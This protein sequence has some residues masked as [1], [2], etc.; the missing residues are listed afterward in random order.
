LEPRLFARFPLTSLLLLAVAVAVK[1]LALV[2][3]AAAAV[4]VDIERQQGLQAVAHRQNQ[5]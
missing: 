5:P 4:L 1:A 3:A 2:V